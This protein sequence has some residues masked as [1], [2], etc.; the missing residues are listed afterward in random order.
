[1][2]KHYILFLLASLIAFSVSA[3]LI[4]NEVLYDPPTP[5]PEGD[6]NGDGVRSSVEDEF[7]EFVNNSASPLDISGYKI[8]DTNYY[9]LLPGTDTPR[10]TV[11]A[12]TIIPAYGIYVLFGGGG[13]LTGIPPGVIVQKASSGALNLNNA[14]DEITITDA[15]D[16]VI[17]TFD[18]STKGLDFG[19]D[20]S[21]TRSPDITGNF[22]LHTTANAAL[23][24]SPGLKAD[25]TTLSIDTNFTKEELSIYPNPTNNG[26]VTIKSQLSSVKNITL[27]DMLGRNVLQ[28]KLNSEVLDV[29]AIKSGLYLLQVSIGDR[30]STSKL[31]IK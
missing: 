8:Y 27:F 14:A 30:S 24:F 6:A 4:I 1:M 25:G 20:Q 12:S 2:K 3:Q 7:I 28:T 26:L 5:F 23:L 18:S 31:I 9:I 10:H 15:S 22:V 17:L 13:L 11:P 21:V 16:N 19:L 29:R